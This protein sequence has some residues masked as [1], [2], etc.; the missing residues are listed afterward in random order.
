MVKSFSLF[1]LLLKIGVTVLG[2]LI[3]SILLYPVAYAF[4]MSIMGREGVFLTSISQLE[5]YGIN[6]WRYIE[7]LKDPEFIKSLTTSVIV[8]VLTILISVIVI[9]PA[10]YGFSRFRFWGR[11]SLL[12]VYLIMS[13]VGGGFGIM[14]TVALYIFLL[15][16]NAIGIPVLGNMFILPVI[17]SSWQVPFMTWLLKT[18]F[19][20]LPKELD[21]AAFIDGASWSTIVFRVVLPASRSALIIIALFSFMGAWGEFILANFLGVSTLAQYIFQ[22]AFGSRGLELPARFAANAILFAIP[23]IIIYVVAQ[24]YIGE[25]MRMGA[26]RG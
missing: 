8:A 16:L 14:A 18:Y 13:Q 24:R 10:A 15:R 1:K 11:D 3:V 21:E 22:T 6:P 4:L 19:D 17:Y 26:V 25:A 7:V 9:T 23:T 12:Y 5:T 2:V 20:S